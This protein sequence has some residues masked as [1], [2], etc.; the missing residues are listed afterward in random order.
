M[1]EIIVQHLVELAKYE[2]APFKS[3]AYITAA[4]NISKANH[5]NWDSIQGVGKAIS[6]K[7][8]ELIETGKIDKL[9]RLKSE[10]KESKKDQKYITL[11]EADEIVKSIQLPF[12]HVVCGSFRRKKKLISDIDILVL[13]KDL[14]S[15]KEYMKSLNVEFINSGDKQ[16]DIHYKDILIN[17]RSTTEGGWGAG[18][19]YLTGSGKFGVLI[20]GLAKKKGFKLNQYGLFK[21]DELIAS[22]TEQ[23]IFDA[24]DLIYIEPHYR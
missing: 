12:R 24:L 11:E 20:R 4:S 17:F 15:I 7:I 8:K 5:T 16:F 1:K 18:M 19:L 14:E 23:D 21:N 9:Q 3:A 2:P 6:S 10:Y 22:S 13:D